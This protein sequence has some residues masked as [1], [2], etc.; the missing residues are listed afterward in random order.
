MDGI[1][2]RTVAELDENM[3]PT[4][5]SEWLAYYWYLDDQRREAAESDRP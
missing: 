2:G 5:F 1:G 3:S 4:E